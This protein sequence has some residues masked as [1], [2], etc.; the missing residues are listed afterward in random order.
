MDR[1]I[2][3]LH[4]LTKPQLRLDG[5]SE[6]VPEA[7]AP[8]PPPAIVSKVQKYLKPDTEQSQSTTVSPATKTVSSAQTPVA[9]APSDSSSAS[10][11]PT[12]VVVSVAAVPASTISTPTQAVADQ[13]LPVSSSPVPPP[14]QTQAAFPPPETATPQPNVSQTTKPAVV[15]KKTKGPDVS[16]HGTV[17]SS[18]GASEYVLSAQQNRHLFGM[19]F[20]LALCGGAIAILVTAVVAYRVY[21]QKKYS[22]VTSNQ[23]KSLAIQVGC[24]LGSSVMMFVVLFASSSFFRISVSGYYMLTILL[25]AVALAVFA[26]VRTSY[27][28]FQADQLAVE[29]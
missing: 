15:R 1:K 10:P 11:Q 27:Y 7:T 24:A 2:Q 19:L 3:P 14:L 4:D 5:A 12:P 20:G 16:D 18:I 21:S 28:N 17:A 23:Y 9:A 8:S 26:Y 13:S 29:K 22:V 25:T 6:S